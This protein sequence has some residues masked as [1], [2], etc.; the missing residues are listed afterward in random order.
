MKNIYLFLLFCAV[1]IGFVSCGQKEKKF[2]LSVEVKGMPVQSVFIEELE[3]NENKLIDS[4][5]SDKEG[6]FE[7]KGSYS[8]P[9]M[10]RIRMGDSLML[11]VIDADLIKIST[12]WNNLPYYS[13]QGSSG[14]AS[15]VSFMKEY[16]AS[17]K[18]ML[19]MGIVLDSL[20]S[21]G[22]DSLLVLATKDFQSKSETFKTFIKNYADTTQCM[23]L[24]LFA[25]GKFLKDPSELEYEKKFAA[26]LGKRFPQNKLSSQ[27]EDIVKE[28]VAEDSKATTGPSVGTIAPDFTLKSIDGKSVSL[29][30]LRGKF[31]LLDFWASWCP[32]CRAENP[33]VVAAYNQYKD[34]NFTIL[35]VSLDKDKDKWQEAITHDKLSWQH[36]SD[37]QGWESSVAALYGVQ[38]IPA[39]FLLDPSGKII[40]VNLRGE[41]LERTLAGTLAGGGLATNA[42]A[43][44]QQ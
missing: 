25:A 15:L 23:P 26:N 27:F 43:V 16:V 4:T 32:P 13:A 29:K 44:P 5:K 34:K 11:V 18:E 42:K 9:G 8:D 30:D 21:T 24:A 20:K 39:N 1:I 17:S 38:S 35:G 6:K 2:H 37:L 40:A 10:Y 33:N 31:V 14:S 7:F 12:T 28:M 36:V 22:T 41:D 19:S 3:F